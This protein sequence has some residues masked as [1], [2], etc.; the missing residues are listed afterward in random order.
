MLELRNGA[1]EDWGSDV[2]HQINAD[3]DYE[4]LWSILPNE[5]TPEQG[6]WADVILSGVAD[7][8]QLFVAFDNHLCRILKPSEYQSVLKGEFSIVDCD[9][10]P[11]QIKFGYNEDDDEWQ[12][13]DPLPD[14]WK[15]DIE[16]GSPCRSPVTFVYYDGSWTVPDLPDGWQVTIDCDGHGCCYC[17]GEGFVVDEDGN[18]LVEN[19]ALVV[20]NGGDESGC[21]E[22]LA[23]CKT[24]NKE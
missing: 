13:I 4:I 11:L 20:C 23:G 9:C 3:G 6:G 22:C 19:G 12:V 21:D 16:C 1:V 18:L 15:V 2:T 10:A 17:T 7:G 14:G 5:S 8:Q 24:Y